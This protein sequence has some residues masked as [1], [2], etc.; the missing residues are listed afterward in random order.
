M[1]VDALGFTLNRRFIAHFEILTCV[2]LATS[3]QVGIHL[4]MLAVRATTHI[5]EGSQGAQDVSERSPALPTIP[6]Y[7]RLSAQTA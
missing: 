2:Y 6:D 3:L 7:K 4:V 1:P 5:G